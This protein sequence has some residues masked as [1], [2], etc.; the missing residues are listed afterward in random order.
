[1][2]EN[3]FAAEAAEAIYQALRT[4]VHFNLM[5]RD[6]LG[7]RAMKNVP[8]DAYAQALSSAQQHGALPMSSTCPN[9]GVLIGVAC[10]NFS[11]RP[12]TQ[13]AHKLQRCS[14]KL[15]IAFARLLIP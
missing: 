11:T 7:Q 13:R 15:L 12:H 3:A 6:A 4:S 1:M 9:T 5:L 10:C 2:I 8:G 14:P